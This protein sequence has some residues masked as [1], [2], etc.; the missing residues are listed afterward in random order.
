MKTIASC[1]YKTK[2]KSDKPIHVGFSVLDLSKLLKYEFCY[3]KLKKYNKNFSLFYV[4][5]NSYFVEMR[6]HPC[7]MM[8]ERAE[9][10]NT[11]TMI[12]T[13]NAIMQLIKK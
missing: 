13:T 12:I 3:D 2:V 11:V 6:K 9:E 7:K 10:F 4:D 8:K 1:V 5:T